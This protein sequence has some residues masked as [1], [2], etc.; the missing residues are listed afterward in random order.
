MR[1]NM[2]NSSI[3]FNTHK[4]KYASMNGFFQNTLDTN[5][6]EKI[7]YYFIDLDY[8]LS[9]Y[10]YTI[11]YFDIKDMKIDDDITNDFIIELL[12]LISHYKQYFYTQQDGIS[13]I[14]IG[15]NNYHY[16]K[17][18]QIEKLIK[19]L[20]KIV[21]MIPKI[22]I[23]YYDNEDYNFFLKYNLIRTIVI[24]KTNTGK[25]PI[26]LDLSKTNKNELFY[27][28]TK[29]YNLFKFDQYRIFLYGYQNFKEEYLRNVDDIYINSIISLLPIYEVLNDIKIN[30]KVRIDDIMLKYIKTHFKED[31]NDIKTQLLILKMFT[32]MKKLESKLIKLNQDLNSIVYTRIMQ[33]V[34]QTWRSIVKDNN[35]YNINEILHVD[36]NKRIN[37]ESL[38]KY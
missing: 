5:I 31:F 30:K 10:L 12:N 29:N 24:S 13:F 6:K 3:L 7:F 36:R 14:Y 2:N 19:R 32:K 4:M 38:M 25:T 33:T 9:K 37:I 34:M 22:Y 20:I 11:G 15:I 21:T 26:F 23:Y 1:L 8:I 18:K 27:K 17:D 28:L 35:I 16:K